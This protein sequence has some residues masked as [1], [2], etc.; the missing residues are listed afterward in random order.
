MLG[1]LYMRILMKGKFIKDKLKEL[2]KNLG[3]SK[4]PKATDLGEYFEVKACQTMKKKGVRDY[5]LK[6]IKRK[7]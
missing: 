2:Y 3:Y 4:S 1:K 6:L 7:E 5:C